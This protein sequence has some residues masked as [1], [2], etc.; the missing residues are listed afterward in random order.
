MT[1]RECPLHELRYPL[2]SVDSAN[3]TLS[4]LATCSGQTRHADL[5]RTPPAAAGYFSLDGLP[6]R[7]RTRGSCSLSGPAR[8]VLH[9]RQKDRGV[10]GKESCDPKPAHNGVAAVGY[11]GGLGLRCSCGGRCPPGSNSSGRA[12]SRP[13]GARDASHEAAILRALGG[14]RRSIWR[15]NQSA[16]IGLWCRYPGCRCFAYAP[17]TPPVRWQYMGGPQGRST[18]IST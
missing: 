18:G 12:V 16:A 10:E 4:D 8:A 9:F 13:L 7:S 6:L 1:I 5:V 3:N 11:L 17:A 2:I 14:S 15:H